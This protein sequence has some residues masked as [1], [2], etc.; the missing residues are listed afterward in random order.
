MK[1]TRDLKIATIGAGYV[2]L[3]TGVCFSD[4][5]YEVICVDKD[6]GKID[7]LNAGEMPIYEDGLEVLVERNVKAGRL[8][9]TTDLSKAAPNADVIFIGVGTPPA[10]DG[11]AD[12]QYVL[13]AA[14]E[15]APLLEGFTVIAIKSTVP[16]GTGDKVEALMRKA[17][18]EADFAVVSNPEFLREGAAI[19]DFTDPDRVIIGT[20]DERARDV[21][22]RLY[23]P[24]SA[25]GPPTV[26]TDR[27][28]SELLKYAANAYLATK[29]SFINE[30]ADLCEAV[31]AN[32]TDVAF[33]MGL[34]DRIG[35][36]YLAPGPGFGGSCFPK[37]TRALL[38][39]AKSA[40][41]KSR[42]VE[43]VVEVNETRKKSM[44]DKVLKLCG[45]SVKGRTIAVLGLAFKPNTDDVRDTPAFPIIKA[46]QKAGAK[47]RAFDPE[48]MEESKAHLTD[49]TYCVDAYDCVRGADVAVLAT[50]WAQFHNLDFNHMGEIMN[51]RKIAD[52]RN[53]Y[54]PED[55]RRHN[56]DYVSIGRA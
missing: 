18:P 13:A 52:L 11:S 37:D 24:F 45:G 27:R 23:R 47:I 36:K 28:T 56:F 50:E 25:L 2:G 44:A 32:V 33:G 38:D 46:L 40:G 53:I 20:T 9:F 19:A 34:D 42:I 5:G 48:A 7:R 21:M 26:F 54:T 15:L 17:A 49:V 1:S 4:F 51:A 30:I 12:I 22:A 8:H 31:G 41:V 14:E 43:Q 10:K 16:V 35:S 55:V 29:I 3:V 39:I 6:A